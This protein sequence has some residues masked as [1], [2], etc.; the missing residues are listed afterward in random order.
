MLTGCQ[1]TLKAGTRQLEEGN[2][3]EAADSFREAAKENENAAEAYRGLG[4][5]LYEQEEYK[6]CIRD[7]QFPA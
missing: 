4:M 1:N 2:Y 3:E 5:A 6:M 7:R